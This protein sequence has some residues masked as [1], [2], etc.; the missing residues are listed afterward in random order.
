MTYSLNYQVKITRTLPTIYGVIQ[1]FLLFGDHD[2]EVYATGGDL[3]IMQVRYDIIFYID[4]ILETTFFILT[5]EPN[6]F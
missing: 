6:A 5:S 2:E 3:E 4:F 1:R